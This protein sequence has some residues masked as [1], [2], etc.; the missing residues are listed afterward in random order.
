MDDRIETDEA[1]E[2]WM[3]GI[4]D[5]HPDRLCPSCDELIDVERLRDPEA[6]GRW[7]MCPECGDPL[8]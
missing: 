8:P 4:S 5:E 2:I 1:T 7:L 3:H 6:D